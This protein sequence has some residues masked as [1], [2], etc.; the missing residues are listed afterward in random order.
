MV[1]YLDNNATTKVDPDVVKTIIPYLEEFYYNPSS[2]YN[3]ALLTRHAIDSA[4]LNIMK[5]LGIEHDTE[6]VFTGSATESNSFAINGV[7]GVSGNRKHIITT[8]VEHPAVFELCKDL[9]KRGY[10]VTYLHVD[11]D[12]NLNIKDLINAIREDTALVSIM[13]ANNETGVV[14]PIEKL[15]RIVKLT[16]PKIVFHTDATQAVGKIDINLKEQLTFV[17]LLSFSGHKIYAPKGVGALF[18]RKGTPIRP[19]IIGGHQEFGMRAGTENI[20]FIVALSKA[21]LL[22]M[23]EPEEEK[24]RLKSLRDELEIFVQKNIPEIKINGK[25]APRICN[26]SDISFYGVEGES[27][28]YALN[29]HG[30]CCS[31]GSACSSGSLAPSHVLQAMNVPFTYAHGSIR[32]SFG[33]FNT[34]KD[35][36]QLKKFLP[37]VISKLREISPYWDNEKNIPIDED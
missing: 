10:D 14:F 25:N 3:Q 33:R 12:G 34:S 17:D 29:E 11:E 35:L 9:E 13:Y 21:C 27:I 1:I 30:I 22:S 8:T 7:L 26:T 15:S 28:L 24:E 16:D 4:R 32:V 23:E 37:P 2:A 5:F 36:E 18:L 6:L 31:T 19:I 20:S